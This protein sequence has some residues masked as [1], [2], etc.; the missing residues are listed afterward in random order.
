MFL[1][2]ECDYGIRVIRALAGNELR[3]VEA[4]C[5]CEHI[6][7]QYAYKILKKLEKGGFV[8]S[9]RGRDGGYQLVK[10]LDS[11]TLLDLAAAINDKL[12]LNEC[13]RDDRPCKRNDELEPCSVHVELERIQGVLAGELSKKT[14]AEICV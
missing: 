10:P 8:K 13:L 4:I 11:I 12:F 9:Q 7:S 3:N 6:P 2:K 5:E 14:I 1:T